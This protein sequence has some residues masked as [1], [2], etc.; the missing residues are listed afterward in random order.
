MSRP[1]FLRRIYPTF[2]KRYMRPRADAD[3]RALAAAVAT[4]RADPG[5]ATV[6]GLW[7]SFASPQHDLRREAG[8]ISA[9]TL[10]V[11]GRR[12]PVIPLR[13]GSKLAASIPGAELVVLETGHVPSTGDPEGFAAVLAPFAERAFAP[14]GAAAK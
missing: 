6:C 11:W 3:R 10:V 2:A 12:D 9:P 5:L 13:I 8:S 4:T 14:S 7:G 1:W